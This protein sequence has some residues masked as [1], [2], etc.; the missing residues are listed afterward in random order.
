M[1]R[2]VT[3]Q[4]EA[5]FPM[6]NTLHAKTALY[7]ACAVGQA[8]WYQIRASLAAYAIT[9]V[10]INTAQ[11]A[12]M[13]LMNGRANYSVPITQCS[14]DSKW[15]CGAIDSQECCDTDTR[16]ELATKLGQSPSSSPATATISGTS[17][18]S[19]QRPAETSTDQSPLSVGDGGVDQGLGQGAKIGLGVGIGLGIPVVCGIAAAIFLRWRRKRSPRVVGLHRGEGNFAK[20]EIGGTPVAELDN[21]ALARELEGTVVMAEMGTEEPKK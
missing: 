2:S 14:R 7:S 21:R 17:T 10:I 16:F 6:A 20:P 3:F 19:D 15:C 8:V 13:T 5:A 1:A 12:R 11:D 4:M 9:G 18:S